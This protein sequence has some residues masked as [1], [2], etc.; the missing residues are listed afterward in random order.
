MPILSWSKTGIQPTDPLSIIEEDGYGKLEM[1]LYYNKNTDPA[2]LFHLVGHEIYHVQQITSGEYH[3]VS[4]LTGEIHKGYQDRVRTNAH[5][6]MNA[7]Q[8]NM[9]LLCQLQFPGAGGIFTQLW[10]ARLRE[11][12]PESAW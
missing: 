7:Y 2:V 1:R 4:I 10:I 11:L 6:E 8:W 9:N 5:M 3:E 12:V